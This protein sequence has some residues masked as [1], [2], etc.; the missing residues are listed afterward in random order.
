MGPKRSTVHHSSECTRDAGLAYKVGLERGL[1]LILHDKD[2]W[3]AD[4]FGALT[5]RIFCGRPHGIVR[6]QG[7]LDD[8][9][10]RQRTASRFYVRQAVEALLT[11]S[12][13]DLLKHLSMAVASFVL[14]K[15]PIRRVPSSPLEKDTV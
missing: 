5:T 12:S 14:F 10:F 6:Y 9:T 13:P 15:I 4:A 8:V 2:Q 3:V 11:G 1:P 7:A